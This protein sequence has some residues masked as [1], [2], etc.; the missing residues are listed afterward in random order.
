[1]CVEPRFFSH[2]ICHT[3]TSTSTKPHILQ[4]VPKKSDVMWPMVVNLFFCSSSLR[5]DR[6][7]ST[8]IFDNISTKSSSFVSVLPY[9]SFTSGSPMSLSFRC[10][11][12]LNGTAG[13]LDRGDRWGEEVG[14]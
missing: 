13:A 3:T 12:R 8:I 7:K 11:C 6:E 9:R 14:E 1:M 4:H 5:L 2:C 10:V